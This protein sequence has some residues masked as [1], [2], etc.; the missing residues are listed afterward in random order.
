M[1]LKFLLEEPDIQSRIRHIPVGGR[2]RLLHFRRSVLG[3][4][5]IHTVRILYQLPGSECQNHRLA[6][7]S[8]HQDLDTGYSKDSMLRKGK[9]TIECN[10]SITANRFNNDLISVLGVGVTGGNNVLEGDDDSLA[11]VLDSMKYFR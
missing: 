9:L 10:V 2:G 4:S 8:N 1:S 11:V 3:R 7:S 6:A 5:Y